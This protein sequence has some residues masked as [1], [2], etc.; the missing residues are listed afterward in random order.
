M[1]GCFESGASAGGQDE[2]YF[3]RPD[4]AG[5][6]G[7]ADENKGVDADRQT[8]S[9]ASGM[10][11][12]ELDEQNPNIAGA[13]PVKD[14]IKIDETAGTESLLRTGEPY[15]DIIEGSD[16]ERTG[17]SSGRP[18]V[19]QGDSRARPNR[20]TGQMPTSEDLR[21]LGAWGTMSDSGASGPGSPTGSAE[22]PDKRTPSSLGGR[23]GWDTGPV[24]TL[25]RTP[26]VCSATTGTASQSRSAGGRRYRRASR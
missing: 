7:V 15:M 14:G 1:S 20:N 17:T 16:S 26:T 3:N 6:G 23:G 8:Q 13:V 10:E 25:S 19:E 12:I 21:D 22:M 5:P 11:G 9:H 24:L 18:G 4:V 2:G